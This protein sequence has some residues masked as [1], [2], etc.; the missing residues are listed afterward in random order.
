M[1]IS[2]SYRSLDCL[3]R[4]RIVL[5]VSTVI[6]SNS[7]PTSYRTP[8]FIGIVTNSIVCRYRIDIDNDIGVSYRTR[9]RYRTE[10]HV[11]RYRTDLDY[12][13]V[14]KSIP[15]SYRTRFRQ[16]T[17]IVKPSAP[18]RQKRGDMAKAGKSTCAVK[19]FRYQVLP[20]KP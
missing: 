17:L 6:V 19:G 16:P 3:Y 20:S 2:V 5:S 1:F 7:I 10:L 18:A 12:D 4:Y 8:L 13:I 14:S 11:N 9:F 15:I